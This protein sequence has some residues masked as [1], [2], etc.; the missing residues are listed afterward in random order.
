MLCQ[1]V[2]PK[3]KM[4]SSFSFMPHPVFQLDCR[5]H[6][7]KKAAFRQTLPN[8]LPV[9]HIFS[10]IITTYSK[11]FIRFKY[12]ITKQWPSELSP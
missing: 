1:N 5:P 11:R 3:N 10:F 9:V 4:S 6:I 8:V 7:E 12:L 2:V